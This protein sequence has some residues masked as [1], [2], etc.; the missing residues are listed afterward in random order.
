[1]SKNDVCIVTAGN[2]DSGK[3]SFVGVLAYGELDDGDGSARKKVA[4]HPHEKD[5]GK[6]SD[7]TSKS[8]R[9]SSEK[10]IMLVDL[11]GH[12]K[13]LKTTLFGMTGYF[14][15]YGI[16]V[17]AAN[18]GLLK[19]SKEHMLILLCLKIPFIILI[20]RVD[21]APKEIYNGTLEQIKKIMK[22]F[23]KN[24]IQFNSLLEYTL[25]EEELKKTQ[26]S[27][28]PEVINT[29]KNMSVNHNIVPIISVSNKTGYYINIIREMV[30]NLEPRN[31]WKTDGIKGSIFYIDSKFNPSGVGSVVSGIVKGEPIKVGDELLLGPYG[32]EFLPVR[33][34]SIHDNNKNSLTELPE[35]CHGCLAFRILDKKTDFV[36]NKIRKGML[37]LS[38]VFTETVC[39]QFNANIKILNHSTTL[40]SKYSPVIHCG[41]IRQTARIIL[42]EN[43]I[44]KMGDR[45]LVS[46]R[47]ISYPEYLEKGMIFFFREGTTKGVGTIEEVL[48]LNK[49]SDPNP[50]TPKKR[51]HRKRHNKGTNN[52]SNTNTSIGGKK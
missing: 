19:M 50:A 47:F 48:P 29:A 16:L 52:N 42:S 36:L 38:K 25:N 14:P 28:L 33:I 1:M 24:P 43:Q 37:F 15:D 26:A 31:I 13:Y 17:V 12:E 10:E 34:W 21:I 49:D 44:L 40:S 46:F 18:R 3:S 32:K 4:K 41:I 20:T 51:S 2:V 30:I 27:I 23:N 39:F 22:R 45:A 8:I 11:C 6:T 7:I 9:I 5:S 35:R